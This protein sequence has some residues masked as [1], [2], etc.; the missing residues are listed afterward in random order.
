[1]NVASAALGIINQAYLK[2]NNC[3]VGNKHRDFDFQIFLQVYYNGLIAM[4]GL[5]KWWDNYPQNG[6]L[7]YA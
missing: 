5:T 6:G 3:V 4:R 2:L 7:T 1:M